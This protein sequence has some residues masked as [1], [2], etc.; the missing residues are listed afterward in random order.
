MCADLYEATA[1]FDV[2]ANG[3]NKNARW[4]FTAEVMKQKSVLREV[5]G[6]SFANVD[7]ETIIQM[8]WFENLVKENDEFAQLVE[9][10]KKVSEI[11]SEPSQAVSE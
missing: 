6:K 10:M 9:K 3:T 8:R 2:F 7:M 4:N 1:D 5:Y 11:E